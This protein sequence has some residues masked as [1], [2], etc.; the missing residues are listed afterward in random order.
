MRHLVSASAA[1]WAG[2]AAVALAPFT[3]AVASVARL[4]GERGTATG[5]LGD[6]GVTLTALKDG[7][8]IYTGTTPLLHDRA[9][10]RAPAARAL[11]RVARDASVPR[12]R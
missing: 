9:L 8:P 12:G 1:Y 5:S 2:L 6:A 10:D 3:I 7:V 4:G 11:D